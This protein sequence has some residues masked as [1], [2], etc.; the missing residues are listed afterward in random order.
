M[1][2]DFKSVP[3]QYHIVTTSD[4]TNFEILEGGFL[5]DIKTECTKGED[6]LTQDIV[7]SDKTIEIR[8]RQFDKH[9]VEARISCKLNIYKDYLASDIRYLIQKGDMGLTR[10]RILH[11]D[12]EVAR[13]EN[14]GRIPNNPQNPQIF[15][16]SVDK[17][18]PIEPL[19]KIFVSL[20]VAGLIILGYFGILIASFLYC[21]LLNLD[22]TEFARLNPYVFIV[23]GAIFSGTFITIAS[24]LNLL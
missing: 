6:R 3:I 7:Y 16:V 5:S 24:K 17:T 11:K 15:N 14:R 13:I 2:Q 22:F 20:K 12:M 1:S 19:S 23:G 21:L 4:W 10:V 8:K 18:P 9:L